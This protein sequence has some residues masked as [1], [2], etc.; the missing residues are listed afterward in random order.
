MNTEMT[1]ALEDTMRTTEYGMG[2][3]RDIPLFEGRY[4]VSNKGMVRS[5]SRPVRCTSH[6]GEEVRIARGRELKPATSKSGHFYLFLGRRNKRQV[7][8]LVAL[9][10]I[11]ERPAGMDIA[12]LNGD[13]TDNRVENLAYVTRRENN[14][15]VAFHG[16]RALT[17]EQVRYIRERAKEGVTTTLRDELAVEIG[18]NRRHISRVIRGASYGYV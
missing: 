6:R 10:F 5:L 18:T 2:E 1:I 17:V 8:A 9:A 11:G 15:H 12:H 4:Q 13:P 14:Q 16:R 7:H 3:W